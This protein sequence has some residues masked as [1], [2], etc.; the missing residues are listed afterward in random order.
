MAP[1][2]DVLT[3]V[4]RAHLFSPLAV[5]GGAQTES[6]LA[7]TLPVSLAAFGHHVQS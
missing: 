5:S 2:Q 6:T 4:K 7:V 1:M 3:R